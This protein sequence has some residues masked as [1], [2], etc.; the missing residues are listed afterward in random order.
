VVAATT[1]LP[2]T[3]ARS[4]TRTTTALTTPISVV[5]GLCL[6]AILR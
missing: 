4:S 5:G 6:A 2:T 3:M 1:S